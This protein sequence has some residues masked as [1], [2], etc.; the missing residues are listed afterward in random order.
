M[1]IKAIR[2]FDGGFMTQAFAFGGED[3]KKSAWCGFEFVF[4]LSA[5][6]VDRDS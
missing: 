5:L 1:E 6:E 2:M 3:A 4:Q